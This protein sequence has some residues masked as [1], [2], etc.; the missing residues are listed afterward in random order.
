MALQIR[1]Y[2][3]LKDLANQVD[4]VSGHIGVV[5]YHPGEKADTTKIGEVLQELGIGEDEVAHIFLNGEYTST[6]GRIAEGDR[7]AVFPRELSL[8]YKWYFNP[9][10]QRDQ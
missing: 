7:L 4:E 9:A 5:N 8:L 2:G 10:S 1:L 6:Q 3:K